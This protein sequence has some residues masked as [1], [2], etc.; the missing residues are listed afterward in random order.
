MKAPAYDLRM[1]LRAMS[2]GARQLF[3]DTLVRGV[4]QGGW[5]ARPFGI[6]E[7][8]ASIEVAN[9]GLGKLC[10]DPEL[11]LMAYRKEQ[12]F[13]ALNGYPIKQGWNKKYTVKFML[14]NAPGVAKRL[15][16]DKQVLVVS[17]ETAEDSKTLLEWVVK[18]QNPLVIAL[19]FM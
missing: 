2:I 7:D 19:G 8:L 12:L 15:A 4:G 17:Q 16:Q 9:L 5:S 1:K 18:I 6:N 11:V 13:A 14:Q 10:G 3:L